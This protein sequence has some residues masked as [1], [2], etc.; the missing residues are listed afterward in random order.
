ML[1]ILLASLS[2]QAAAAGFEPAVFGLELPVSDVASAERAYADA[3]GFA[4]VLSGGE[5]ARLEKDG[6]ALLLVRSDAPRAAEGS[7]RVH[8]NLRTRDIDAALES[9]LAAGFDAPELEPHAIPIGRALTLVDPDGHVTNL[10]EVAAAAGAA[11]ENA[12][13]G[14]ELAVFNVGLSLEPD[15][16]REFVARLGFRVKT[17]AYLPDALPTEKAGAAE[18]VLRGTASAPRPNG[19]R[20]AT[21]LLAVEA[22]QPA[23]DVLA[24]AGFVDAAAQ[25]RATPHGRRVALRVPSNLRIE[26]IERSPAQLAF[27]RLCALAGSWEGR[28]SAG[29][30]ARSEIEVIARGSAVLERTNFE[31]HP[32]ETMLTLFHRDGEALVLTHYCVAGNQPRLAATAID[33]GRL[34][35]TFHDATNLATRD[36]G[37]MDEAFFDLGDGETFA[38]K[39]SFSQNGKTSWMEEIEYRRVG[40]VAAPAP[41]T[42]GTGSA[43]GCGH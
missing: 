17:R 43:S 29:W 38:S 10:I 22:L 5:L 37:H 42:A 14:A 27:E 16:D 26:L 1:A 30:T 28:S 13:G 19:A 4:S 12:A 8:L 41:A 24:P 23:L 31:A 33:G 40:A 3:F 20:A 15:A 25:P 34:H 32:G 18:L 35:F 21:L 7:A 39:W 11:P 2:T 6:L 36:V 9:A